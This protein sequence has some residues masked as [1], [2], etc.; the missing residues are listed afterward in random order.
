[1]TD[2]Y[3]HLYVRLLGLSQEQRRDLLELI[4]STPLGDSQIA[5]TVS[6][7]CLRSQIEESTPAA[8]PA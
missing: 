3:S 5:S 7:A 6:S 1:M 2:T 8:R 4:G